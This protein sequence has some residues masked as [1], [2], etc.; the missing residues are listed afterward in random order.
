MYMKLILTAFLLVASPI[1]TVVANGA[2]EAPYTQ[3][4]DHVIADVAGIG[5]TIDI[6]K[7]NVNP[8]GIGIV[9]VAS[10]GWNSDRNMLNVLEQ[11]A[12]LYTIFTSHGYTVFTVRPGSKSKF[13]ASEMLQNVNITIEYV[14][15]NSDVFNID[16]N[17][18]ALSGWSAGA[19][20]AALAAVS[21]ESTSTNVSA[22]G[23]FFPPT[24]FLDW[25]ESGELYDDIDSLIP[26]GL[27]DVEI[28]SFAR[29]LSPALNIG[30]STPPFLIWHGD[31]DPIV[32][33]QQ[34]EYFVGKLH[35]AGVFAELH[36][37]QGGRH[38][39]AGIAEQSE[40]IAEWF[41]SILLP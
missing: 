34:S 21:S 24:N 13:T 27:T 18:L 3:E 1:V 14:K 35:E 11:A 32:P 29:K 31:E 12:N 30:P 7:P 23:L 19:H 15:T 5:L 22:V 17:N 4:K 28:L 41:D 36:V 33:L 37:R 25:G 2:T 6:F 10:G 39:W 9:V 20:L 40:H 38:V 16:P 8:N 26:V